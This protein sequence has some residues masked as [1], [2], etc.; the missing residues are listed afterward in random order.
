MYQVSDAYKAAM[1]APVQQG[2][3]R[4]RIQCGLRFYNYT[5]ANISKG[6]FT[7]SHECSGNDNVEIGTVYT[8][9]L[10]TTLI[11]LEIARGGLKDAILTPRH[12]LKTENGW[13]PVPL[14]IFNVKE[15][16]WT[17]KGIELKAYDNMVKFD[18]R[19]T[20]TS[21]QGQIFDYL[22]LACTACKVELA[23][24]R[25]DIMAMPNGAADLAIYA[26]NDIETW[27]DLV[28]WCAQTTGTFATINREGKLELRAYGNDAVDVI[29]S[30]RRITGAKFS[31][32]ETRYTGLSCVNIAA[33]TTSYYGLEVDDGLTYNLGSNPLLQYGL[34]ETLANQRIAILNAISVINYVPMEV[35]MIGTPA[36]DLGDVL[37][38]S[39]GIA[40][41]TKMSCITKYDWKYGGEYQVTG[42]G[43]NPELSNARSKT[44][45]DI[46]GLMAQTQQDV[47]KYYDYLNARAYH[48]EDGESENIIDIRYITAKN[49]HVDFHAE[50]KYELETTEEVEL[51]DNE[52]VLGYTEHDGVLEVTYLLNGEEVDTYYPVELEYDGTH[53]LHLLFTWSSSANVIGNF[54][55]RL[56][57][58]GGSLD[59]AISG[60]RAYMAGQGLVGDGEWDGNVNVSDEFEAIDMFGAIH[61]FDTT[62]TGST[63]IPHA[64]GC[65]DSFLAPDMYHA[66][67]DFSDSIGDV[68]GLHRYTAYIPSELDYD[69]REISVFDGEF[70]LNEGV[71]SSTITTPSRP[72][73]QILKV[74]SNM[75]GTN[76]GF[77]VSFDGGVNWWTYTSDWVEPDYTQD[78]YGMFESRLRTITPEKWAE[79]LEGEIMIK[80]LMLV[81]ARLA[82]IQIYLEEIL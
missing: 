49:T 11:D 27:R 2:R 55:V 46:S 38:F 68:Y 63:Y 79:K 52:E 29:G 5:E 32:F 43:Q 40:D 80:V 53:L 23:H 78:M 8:A 59:I 62:A 31:D 22:M 36:Y 65:T 48:L 34:D 54:T 42:V 75:S 19:C 9:E 7:L 73:S 3:L 41:A 4:G 81:G 30:E 45:K 44:D 76:V 60:I 51:G 24:T 77:I 16:Y 13:E 39:D 56:K 14:G 66:I 57:A 71:E 61:D 67:P 12:E 64:A 10:T 70:V 82:D 58:T 69:S 72:A 50:V 6:S 28:A 37:I 17:E 33:Q 18:K 1:V 25:A 20:L 47:M 26:E 15:A 74:T 21:S 35:S